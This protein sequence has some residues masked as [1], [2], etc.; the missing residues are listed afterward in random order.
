MKS[1]LSMK[2]NYNNSKINIKKKYN[3]LNNN[4]INLKLIDCQMK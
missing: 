2:I 4:K 3:N 1:K